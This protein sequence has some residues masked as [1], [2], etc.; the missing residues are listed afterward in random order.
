MKEITLYI[1]KTKRIEEIENKLIHVTKKID[2]PNVKKIIEEFMKIYPEYSLQEVYP[3]ACRI[4]D[5][6]KKS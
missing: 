6:L 5:L 3:I 4:I 2:E 1:G